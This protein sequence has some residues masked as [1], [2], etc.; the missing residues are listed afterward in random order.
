MS[1]NTHIT[2]LDE[3][4]IVDSYFGLMSA[5]SAIREQTKDPNQPIFDVHEFL[6]KL[7]QNMILHEA[8]CGEEHQL[9]NSK[10]HSLTKP[11][12]LLFEKGI[13]HSLLP[14]FIKDIFSGIADKIPDHT[15]TSGGHYNVSKN[16]TNTKHT[17]YLDESIVSMIKNQIFLDSISIN[18]F[19]AITNP[20]NFKNRIEITNKFSNRFNEFNIKEYVSK[21]KPR[22]DKAMLESYVCHY[23][24]P[25]VGT[26][27]AY[28]NQTVLYVM[29]YFKK[30]DKKESLANISNYMDKLLPYVLEYH[31][32]IQE[33]IADCVQLCNNNRKEVV[34]TKMLVRR[35]GSFG[36]CVIFFVS[37]L[38]DISRKKQRLLPIRELYDYFREKL[39]Y[40]WEAYMGGYK[41]FGLK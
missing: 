39:S 38:N 13:E 4:G 27:R 22:L 8:F 1:D 32:K 14:G 20:H 7:R 18:R 16:P 33:C 23:N 28:P 26:L 19:S 10:L 37:F 17:P 34:I 35:N 3:L 2:P 9:K 15:P 6:I 36:I 40:D 21:R 11:D 31:P 30:Y 25:L 24:I 12:F 41:R 5:V 29:S